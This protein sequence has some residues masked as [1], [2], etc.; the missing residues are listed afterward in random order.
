M[1][2]G[3]GK[4][5]IDPIRLGKKLYILFYVLLGYLKKLAR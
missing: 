2:D 3:Y 4:T 1:N 5:V